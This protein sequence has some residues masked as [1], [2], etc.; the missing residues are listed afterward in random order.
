MPLYP[1]DDSTRSAKFEYDENDPYYVGVVDGKIEQGDRNLT[2][3]TDVEP[4]GTFLARILHRRWSDT[5]SQSIYYVEYEEN[6]AANSNPR[7]YRLYRTGTENVV[8][9]YAAMF[10][11][12]IRDYRSIDD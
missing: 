4:E 5:R 9:E 11:E 2:S 3:L 6:S 12:E 8:K 10:E 7:K 1:N